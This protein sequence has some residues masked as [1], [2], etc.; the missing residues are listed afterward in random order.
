MKEENKKDLHIEIAHTK[1]DLDAIY[2][3]RYE[4]YCNEMHSLDPKDYPDKRESDWYDQYS[5]YIV[6]KLNGGII[7]ALR[8]IK[9]T[10]RGFLMEE[11]FPLPSWIDKSKAVEHSRGVMQKDYRG[12]GIFRLIL[13]KAYEWQKQN[14]YPIC[15]GTPVMNSLG[16]IITKD[17]WKPLEDKET[18]YHN[19]ITVPMFYYLNEK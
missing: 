5:I 12:K 6:A 1:E 9:N 2:R 8:L 7:G 13:D 17:G 3:L 19:I 15:V 14:G 4:I 10:P 16:P 18:V 11:A